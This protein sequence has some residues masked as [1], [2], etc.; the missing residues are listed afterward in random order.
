MFALFSKV[1]AGFADM[2]W[3]V[4][5][6]SLFLLATLVPLEAIAPPARN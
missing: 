5:F 6:Q 2:F 1:G 4:L 3:L